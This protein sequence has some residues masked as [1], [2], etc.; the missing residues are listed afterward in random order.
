MALILNDRVRETTA[1]TGTGSAT[2]LGA[3]TGYQSFSTIGNG[4]TTYYTIADQGG[5]NWEVGLGTYSSGTLART[6]VLSSSN[7]GS[8]V[9]FTAG[10][11]DVFVTQPSEKAV[12]LDGSGNITPSSVGPLTVSSLTDSGLTSGRVTYAGTGGLLQDSANLTFNGTTLTA[13]TLNLT[14]ALTTSYGGTGLTSFTAGDLPYYS[15]GT[16]LSK[17]AIGT[18]GYILQ[19]NGSAPTWVL[20]SSVIGGAGGSNTQVQYNSSGSL[21]GSANMTFN[22]T[23]LTLAND[24]SISGLTVGKGGG[25]VSTNTALGNSALASNTTGSTNTAVGSGAGQSTTTGTRLTVVGYQAGF[26]NTTGGNLTAIGY[27]AGR[28]FNTAS[29]NY[30]STFVGHSAGSATTTGIDNTVLGYAFYTNTTGSYNI[31]IGGGALGSNTTASNN[32][33]VGYQ[34]GYSNTTG[35]PNTYFGYRSG[36]S[37]AIGTDNTGIGI[38][39]LYTNTGSYNTGL[40]VSALYANTSGQF[41]TGLG[42]NSL[43]ANTTGS[44]NVG[45]GPYA[46][47]SNTTASNNTAVGYQA[48]YSNTTGSSVDAFGYQALYANTGNYNTAFGYTALKANTSGTQNSAFGAGAMP[49]NTTGSYN[50]AMGLNAMNTNTTGSNNVGLGIQALYTNTTGNQNTVVGFQAG[51]AGSAISGNNFFGTYA[52]YYAAGNNNTAIGNA[53]YAQNSSASGTNNVA[54]GNSALFANTSGSSN[55]AIGFQAGNNTTTG[56][57]SVYVGGNA[58][59]SATTGQYN[60]VVGFGAGYSLTTG[61]G[62]SFF[63]SSGSSNGYGAGYYVTTG[64]NNTILG[65]YTGNQGGLDIRTASNYIVLSDGAGNPRGYW[66]NNGQLILPP[67]A[68]SG[69]TITAKASNSGTSMFVANTSITSGTAYYAYFIYNGSATGQITSTGSVTL[70]TSLSDQRLKENIVDAGSGLAKLSNVKVRSFDW[71]TNQEKTDF[72]LVA[73]ELNEVAPEAVVVGVDKDDGSIDKPWQVDSSVLVPAMIKAIQE[74]SAE[75]TELKAK[76]GA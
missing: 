34:A 28:S 65:A 2:L 8:L 31:A 10:T 38:N 74:L 63:G 75:V 18:N 27:V 41:N 24:A 58:G 48:G 67:P 14:N 66:D 25:S 60:A 39:A 69:N 12:Y 15:T 59:Y 49:A 35:A 52:G 61:S 51:Y 44:Y 5:P 73:Q 45:V 4:N 16:A 55:T 30:A 56:S 21:A 64:A 26:V 76:L 6:T 32:T 7:S 22:G 62:N 70:F 36:Y 57:S 13:N 53:A 47:N 9:N 33:A 1:V 19:S 17:L 50:I 43:P 37:N 29:D 72:G 20:A 68:G 3:V 40:G 46:L 42:W 11:K 23:T 54:V 71:K